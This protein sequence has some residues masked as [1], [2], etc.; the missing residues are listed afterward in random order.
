MPDS[1]GGAPIT[2]LFDELP[3]LHRFLV[4][5]AEVELGTGYYF[6]CYREGEDI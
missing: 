6:Y 2:S 4:V 3:A 5:V 1:E